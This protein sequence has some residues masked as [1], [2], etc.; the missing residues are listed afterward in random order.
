M[1]LGIVWVRRGFVAAV[2]VQVALAACSG[3]NRDFGEGASGQASSVAGES[4]SGNAAA[5]D[6]SNGGAAS[7]SDPSSNGE[8]GDRLARGG[9]GDQGNPSAPNGGAPFGGAA[10]VPGSAGESGAPTV[11]GGDSLCRNGKVEAGEECDD[12]NRDD[13]DGCTD[14]KID[15][16]W[17]CAAEPSSCHDINECTANTYDCS[18]YGTC[19]NTL[20]SYTCGCATGYQG[21]GQVCR[22]FP[23]PVGAIS[24]AGA[25]T[26]WYQSDRAKCWGLING[27]KDLSATT[28]RSLDDV[29]QLS[30]GNTHFCALSSSGGVSCWGSNSYGETGDTS[31]YDENDKPFSVEG[32]GDVLQLGSGSVTDHS[33]VVLTSGAAKCWGRGDSGQLGNGLTLATSP[34]VSVKLGGIIQIAMGAAHTCALLKNREVHCWG[35]NSGHQLGDGGTSPSLAPEAVPTLGR[36]NAQVVV[37][38]WH[39]CVLTADGAVKC[40]GTNGSGELGSIPPDGATPVAVPLPKRAKGLALGAY[41]SCAILSDNTISC[42]GQNTSGQIGTGSKTTIEAPTSLDF[43]PEKPV[44]IAAGS[45][46]T[47]VLFESGE[48]KCW[49]LNKSGQLGNNKTL[50]SPTP[51]GVVGIGSVIP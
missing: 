27:T 51:V 39:S 35:D 5:G 24:S 44:G 29:A 31:Q 2:F 50:D 9:A 6:D 22:P 49:G 40:W 42:W 36:D 19:S 12:A 48:A 45:A 3:P 7:N 30:G 43:S 20:G 37:G 26:C 34:P 21:D 46:H 17:T 32:L 1:A 41:H 47:C 23:S 8:G 4:T 25:G 15:A 14:C 13:N 18:F 16:G 10:T 38:N 11:P 33:C 28:I